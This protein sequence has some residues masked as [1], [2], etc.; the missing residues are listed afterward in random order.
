MRASARDAL[1]PLSDGK[2]GEGDRTR[3]RVSSLRTRLVFDRLGLYRV[4]IR[5]AASSERAI[6]CYE[7]AGF[8]REGVLR[9]DRNVDGRL[10]ASLVMSILE[11]EYRAKHTAA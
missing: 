6:R 4:G 7:R 3:A 1:F 2:G 11:P 8:R 5:V 9:C 10:Q